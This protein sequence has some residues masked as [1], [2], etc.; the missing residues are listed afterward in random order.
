MENGRKAPTEKTRADK[1]KVRRRKQGDKKENENGSGGRAEVERVRKQESE[2][3]VENGMN[4]R[5]T[6][7]FRFQRQKPN[8][9]LQHTK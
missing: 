5:Q 9:S 1:T 8:L 2:R 3:S 7:I 6:C 4:K